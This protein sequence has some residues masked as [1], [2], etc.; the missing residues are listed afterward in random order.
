MHGLV[1]LVPHSTKRINIFYVNVINVIKKSRNFILYAITEKPD[2][3]MVT[4]TWMNT[5][6]KINQ[7]KEVSIIKS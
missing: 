3:I 6:E 1:E 4:E 5:R 2:L 7:K